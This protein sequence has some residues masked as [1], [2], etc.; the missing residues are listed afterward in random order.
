M[1]GYF[2]MTG[3]ISEAMAVARQENI[4]TACFG[5]LGLTPRTTKKQERNDMWVW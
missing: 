5:A 4:C 2:K 1:N 3:A